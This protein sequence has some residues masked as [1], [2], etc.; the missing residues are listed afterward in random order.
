MEKFYSVE[1]SVQPSHKTFSP[2][3]VDIAS[4]VRLTIKED[5]MTGEESEVFV[6]DVTR[7]S[8]EEYIEVLNKENEDLNKHLLES[9][10]AMAE[11]YEGMMYNG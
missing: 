3:I 5:P 6:C 7:Y 8:V 11:M 10:E 1:S 2:T 4:N 9:Q